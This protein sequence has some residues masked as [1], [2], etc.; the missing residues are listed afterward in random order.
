MPYMIV[1]LETSIGATVQENMRLK[2]IVEKTQSIARSSTGGEV[3]AENCYVLDLSR[4]ASALVNIVQS[5]EAAGL[6]YKTVCLQD[7]PVFA[8]Q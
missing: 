7:R 4:G 1:V 6:K 3:I 2:S 5:L 8:S